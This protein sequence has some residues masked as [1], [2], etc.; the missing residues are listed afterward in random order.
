MALPPM[1]IR[2]RLAPR[3]RADLRRIPVPKVLALKGLSSISW[4]I[5]KP[6]AALISMTAVAEPGTQPKGASI[7]R[8]WASQVFSLTHSPAR[9]VVIAKAVPS[10]PSAMGQ[11]SKIAPGNSRSRLFLR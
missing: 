11:R 10:P 4:T 1:P 9:A 3:R 7:G 8:P 6:L 2:M 5:A